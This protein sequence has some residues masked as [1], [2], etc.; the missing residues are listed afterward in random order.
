MCNKRPTGPEAQLRQNKT[1]CQD[2]LSGDT[3]PSRHCGH[4]KGSKMSR[5]FYQVDKETC[6]R[7][8]VRNMAADSLAIYF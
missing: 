1:A 8:C 5:Q 7:T 2:V 6:S 4:S 3:K